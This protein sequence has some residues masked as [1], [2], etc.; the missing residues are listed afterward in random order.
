MLKP[1]RSSC[2][3]LESRLVM[4]KAITDEDR[5]AVMKLRFE[6]F[7]LELNEGLQRSYVTGLD[8]DEIDSY[9]DHIMIVDASRH[10]VIG[11]YRLLLGS[12]AEKGIGYYAEREFEISDLKRL[13]IY[14]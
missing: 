1:S 13:K 11:T 3:P 5:E 10:L 14:R 4:R 6:V 2:V 8:T 9:C 7:N 12:W